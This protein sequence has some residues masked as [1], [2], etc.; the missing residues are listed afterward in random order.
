MI[1]YPGSQGTLLRTL[2]NMGYIDV[3]D[4]ADV[5]DVGRRADANRFFRA[6]GLGIREVKWVQILG[7]T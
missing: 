5:A 7:F 3:A 1:R 2:N 4:V 6:P